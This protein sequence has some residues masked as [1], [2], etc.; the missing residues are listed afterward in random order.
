MPD[1]RAYPG[2]IAGAVLAL[3]AVSANAVELDNLPELEADLAAPKEPQTRDIWI[4]SLGAFLVNTGRFVGS[5]ERATV[6][7]PLVYFSYNDFVYWSI[8]SVGAWLVRSDDR[9]FRLGLLAKVRGRIDGEDLPFTGIID[10]DGSMEAGLNLVWRTQG[11]TVGASWLADALDRSN[12]E[13]ANLRLSLPIRLNEHWTTTPSVSAEWLDEQMVDYYYGV[14]PT[15]TA[16][17]APVYAGVATVNRRIGWS[18]SYRVDRG[19][20]ALAGLSYT[21]LGSGIADS[22]LVSRSDNLL[23]YAGFAWTFLKSN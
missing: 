9:T 19:W 5:D 12:G 2:Y 14:R 8:S 22:P 21:K 3:L 10:R 17:G 16:G 4:G 7:L 11:L 6:P 20:R 18:L 13:T 15:E 1:L 23:V